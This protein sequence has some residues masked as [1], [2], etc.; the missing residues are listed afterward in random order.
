MAP[1]FWPQN[2]PRKGPGLFRRHLL[3]ST[4]QRICPKLSSLQPGPCL[5][6]APRQE[7]KRRVPC[8]LFT[9]WISFYDL[10]KLPFFLSAV[11]GIPLT[12]RPR[13]RHIWGTGP[14]ATPHFRGLRCQQSHVSSCYLLLEGVSSGLTHP[15]MGWWLREGRSR[16]GAVARGPGVAGAALK[17]RVKVVN[18]FL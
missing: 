14:L 1:S 15:A 10:A 6:A 12:A 16:T 2:S 4:A 17:G 3:G 11:L 8:S 7:Q 13:V 9:R 5:Q 18:G